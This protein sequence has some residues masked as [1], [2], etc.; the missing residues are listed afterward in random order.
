MAQQTYREKLLDPR[1][2]KKRLEVMQRANF[3]CEACG[4]GSSTLH[5][6]HGF[7]ERGHDPWDHPDETLKC[8]C[9]SCH[10]LY[11]EYLRDLHFEIAKLNP[12]DYSGLM[13]Y[14][15]AYKESLQ[16]S[17]GAMPTRQPGREASVKEW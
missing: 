3:R 11:G 13:G 5:V 16:E 8:V 15:L 6:H 4:D 14:I 9:E 12:K 7:Y 17:K 2:Q 1:W 10:Q